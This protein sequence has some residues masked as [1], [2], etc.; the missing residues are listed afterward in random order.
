MARLGM[1]AD[2][3]E[4]LGKQLRTQG[5]SIRMTVSKVDALVN[6]AGRQWDGGR[7]R[8]F[9]IQWQLTHRRDLLQ[10]AESIEGL[11]QAA[12]NNASE[13]RHVSDTS[14]TSVAAG[15]S[16]ARTGAQGSAEL[17]VDS[18]TL[19]DLVKKHGYD[20]VKMF[21]D[22]MSEV[23]K[24][25]V[26]ERVMKFGPLKYFN[27]A[28]TSALFVED[29]NVAFDGSRTF[30]DRFFSG[31]DMASTAI[32]LVPGVGTLGS[33]ALDVGS[34]AAQEAMKADWSVDAWEQMATYI[35]GDYERG[36][37]E[38]TVDFSSEG[39]QQVV[40]YVVENP[41]P[42]LKEVVESMPEV[43]AA[44]GRAVGWPWF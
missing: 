27:V 35:I 30:E 18:T 7:S 19:D 32:G 21:M 3:V 42:A 36:A 41:G 8:A 38:A 11:G 33:I 13:Q 24:D 5:Q 1:D 43:P 44:I 31:V 25:P 28:L 29:V 20:R 12:L 2:V 26:A 4:A 16:S 40:E 34:F 15:A 10:L 9:V 17:P 39:V 14:G 22:Y 23:Q 6:Q 37:T